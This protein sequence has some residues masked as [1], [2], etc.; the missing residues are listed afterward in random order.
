LANVLFVIQTVDPAILLIKGNKLGNW[1]AGIPSYDLQ[2]LNKP[3]RVRGGW[4]VLE[5]RKKPG[6]HGI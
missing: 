2:L 6:H 4:A 5:Q 3:G 1:V